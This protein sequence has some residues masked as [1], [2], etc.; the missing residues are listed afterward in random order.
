LKRFLNEIFGRKAIFL[1]ENEIFW[2]KN[3]KRKTK[4]FGEKLNF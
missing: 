1:E 3:F 2:K 4:F